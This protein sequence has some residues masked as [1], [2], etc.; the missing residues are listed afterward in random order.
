MRALIV[1]EIAEHRLFL[2]FPVILV[3]LVLAMG[4]ALQALGL[5]TLDDANTLLVG[6]CLMVPPF[7]G[8]LAGAPLFA[9]E[10]SRGTVPLLFGLPFSRLRIWGAK[11]A[12]GALLALLGTLVFTAPSLTAA[13]V[14][15]RAS[16][17]SFIVPGLLVLTLTPL[18]LSLFCSVLSERPLNALLAGLML[19]PALG[20]APALA[21]TRLEGLGRI[22]HDPTALFFILAV[23]PIPPLLW[24]SAVTVQ[25]GETLTRARKWLVALLTLGGGLLLMT[26]VA[27][28][29]W[30]AFLR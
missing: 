18:A 11:A 9:G 27:V 4:S 12:A 6:L 20:I 10:F 16:D 23:A 2:L 13:R 24:A 29:A 30:A 26:P 28:L 21:I 22:T 17:L 1:K 15:P 14:V 8:L 19:T 3:V 7:L 5:L 25:R